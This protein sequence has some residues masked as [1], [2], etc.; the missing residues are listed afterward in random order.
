MDWTYF[1]IL[2]LNSYAR[3][4]IC[5]DI[6]NTGIDIR[7]SGFGTWNL[8]KCFPFQVPESSDVVIECYPVTNDIDEDIWYG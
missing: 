1:E 2:C 7:A 6:S 3:K 5:T 8:K 4:V